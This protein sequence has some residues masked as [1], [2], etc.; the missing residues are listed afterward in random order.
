MA[1]NGTLTEE[2]KDRS[3]GTLKWQTGP[4]GAGL[5]NKKEGCKDG[6]KL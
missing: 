1:I 6:K 3:P 4:G 2:N 5:K